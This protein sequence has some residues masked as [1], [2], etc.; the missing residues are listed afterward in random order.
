VTDTGGEIPNDHP[1]DEPADGGT[2]RP[3]NEPF[4]DFKASHW[5]TAGLTLALVFVGLAQVCV[6]LRQA[7][8]MDKQATISAE[9][10]RIT[11]IDERAFV[12][13]R[14]IDA[15]PTLDKDGNVVEW[16]IAPLWENG[17]STATKNLKMVMDCPSGNFDLNSGAV[18]ECPEPNI[19][20]KIGFY[21]RSLGP[22]QTSHNEGTCDAWTPAQV[23]AIPNHRFFMW[24]YAR[25][26]D[27]FDEPHKTR[28]CEGIILSG[29]PYKADRLVVQ[30]AIVQGGNCTDEVCDEQ[31]RQAD[32]QKK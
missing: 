7:G 11:K 27:A 32:N 23:A 8:I 24:A 4:W 31:D 19:R 16:R 22:H 17:G 5:T 6:Y 1:P 29:D 9:Q 18:I 3:A 14:Q 20:Y 12:F 15:V 21:Q 13:K 26:T 25:Y 28:F 10:S 30:S 2:Q